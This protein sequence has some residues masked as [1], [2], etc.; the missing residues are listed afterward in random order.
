M[1]TVTETCEQAWHV[2]RPS[3]R[4]PYKPAAMKA[5]ATQFGAISIRR[6]RVPPDAGWYA[7]PA[8]EQPPA[9]RT[10]KYAGTIERTCKYQRS[11]YPVNRFFRQCCGIGTAVPGTDRPAAGAW[12]VR[13]SNHRLSRQ[14]VTRISKG[15]DSD[16]AYLAAREETAQLDRT[17]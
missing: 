10:G 3:W 16:Q 14:T 11:F 15:K 7:N 1:R 17:W 5:G 2:G 12:S 9:T 6:R 13:R 4:D 8:C